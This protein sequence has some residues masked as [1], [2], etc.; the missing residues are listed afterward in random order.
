MRQKVLT[1]TRHPW[2]LFAIAADAGIDET[3]IDR[4][5]RL[6]VEAKPLDDTGAEILDQH[7]GPGQQCLQRRKIGRVL[8]VNR[9]A[10]LGAVDRMENRRIPA[11]FRIAEIKPAGEV[12][13]IGTL[14]LDDTGAE[15]HQPQRSV[16][17]RQELAHID[18]EQARQR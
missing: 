8:Q 13:A 1:R 2:A 15:I 3:R 17:A 4:L 5:H 18:D 11:D 9:E 10:F 12:A 14:D 7:V 6:I 16:G